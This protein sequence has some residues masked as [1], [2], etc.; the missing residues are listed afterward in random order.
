MQLHNRELREIYADLLLHYAQKYPNLVIVE[1]DLMSASK[2]K[3][4]FENYPNRAVNVGVAEANMMGVAAGLANMGKIPFT[5]TFTP[6]ATRRVFD[7]VTMSIAYAGM[8]V[9]MV[10]SDP[11]VLAELNGGTHMSFEDVG[12]MRSLATMTIFEPVDGVQLA[13]MFEQIIELKT[14]IYIRLARKDFPSIFEDGT[15]FTLGK[16]SPIQLGNDVSIFASGIMVKEAIDAANVLKEKGISASVINIHTIKPLDVEFV[17][18]EA[19]R[20]HAVVTAENHNYM[21]GLGSAIAEALGEHYPT[22]MERVGI[23]DHFGEVGKKDFLMKKYGL[24]SDKIVDAA[25][26]V[27][28]RKH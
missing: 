4:F 5:H 15:K 26:R 2:T 19:K 12:L 16:A 14:P 25:L 23:K 11:G 10:G 6:F 24:T 9:K 1:A 21:N 22:V 3:K 18:A 17:I 13:S 28:A 20:T 27:I 8:A 7:Q